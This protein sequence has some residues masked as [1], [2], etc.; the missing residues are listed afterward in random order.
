MIAPVE[1][2]PIP[3]GLAAVDVPKRLSKTEQAELRVRL[4][5]RRPAHLELLA[6]R[7]REARR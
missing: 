5:A 7:Q 3:H 2:L 1:S 6:R 4:G